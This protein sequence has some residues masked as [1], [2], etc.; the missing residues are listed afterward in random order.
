MEANEEIVVFNP[1]DLNKR[2]NPFF[3][4]IPHYPEELTWILSRILPDQFEI[5]ASTEDLPEEIRWIDLDNDGHSEKILLDRLHDR[6]IVSKIA[7]TPK[8]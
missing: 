7:L 3:L 6:V 4:E 8:H 5:A 1:D 2:I